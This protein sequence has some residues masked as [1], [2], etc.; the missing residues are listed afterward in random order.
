MVRV[1]KKDLP[2]W[3]RLLVTLKIWQPP[4]RTKHHELR[5]LPAPAPAPITGAHGNRVDSTTRSRLVPQR[6]DDT[7]G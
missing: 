3:Q 1:N 6:H 7:Q 4:H 2:W 5:D